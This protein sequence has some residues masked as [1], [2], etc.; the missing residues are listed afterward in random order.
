[1]AALAI[2]GGDGR[3]PTLVG[4]FEEGAPIAGFGGPLTGRH[5]PVR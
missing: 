4:L 3:E 2:A 5:A 1:M